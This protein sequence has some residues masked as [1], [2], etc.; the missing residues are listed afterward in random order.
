SLVELIDDVLRLLRRRGRV[1]GVVHRLYVQLQLDGRS[2]DRDA[3][4]Q[5]RAIVQ[6]EVLAVQ[7]RLRQR[8]AAKF[9]RVTAVHHAQVCRVQADGAADAVHGEGA[10][11]RPLGA[12]AVG[13]PG[14]DE[15][16]VRV[17]L[18][19]E[20]VGGTQ[21]VVTGLVARGNAGGVDAYRDLGID[22]V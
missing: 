17:A 6:G 14:A 19:V 11:Q 10:V 21:V 5:H 22:H 16:D 8:R 2:D 20:E 3:A 13:E 7:L 1:G 9:L 15:V 4:G 18:D 12:T